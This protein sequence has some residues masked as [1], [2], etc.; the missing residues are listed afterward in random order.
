MTAQ[1]Q[2]DALSRAVTATDAGRR[3]GWSRAFSAEASRD[4]LARD[5]NILR[6]ERDILYRYAS[7]VHGYVRVLADVVGGTEVQEPLSRYQSHIGAVLD[8]EVAKAGRH[9]AK[10]GV[11]AAEDRTGRTAE[12][13][14]AR[15]QRKIAQNRAHRDFRAAREQERKLLMKRYGF[16]NEAALFSY[17][18]Q[19]PQ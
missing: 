6:S 10:V 18:E 11:Q 17:L 15:Q 13:D 14:A 12:R 1:E 5:V 9:A 4:A 3:V 2:I 7:F 8:S 19:Y 16:P